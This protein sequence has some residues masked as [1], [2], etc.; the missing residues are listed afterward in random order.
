QVDGLKTSVAQASADAASASSQAAA[1]EAAANRAAQYA[2]DTNSKLDS[3]FK[4]SMMK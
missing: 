3:M 2:Q 1:A 4:K